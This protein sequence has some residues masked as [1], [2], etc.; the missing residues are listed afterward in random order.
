MISIGSSDK[1]LGKSKKKKPA[2]LP[3]KRKRKEAAVG[4]FSLRNLL[5]NLQCHRKLCERV[6]KLQCKAI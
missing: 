3:L 2:M 1:E 6:H 5:L 4:F